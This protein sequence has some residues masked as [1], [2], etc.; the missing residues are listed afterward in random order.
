MPP[1][2]PA[3]LHPSRVAFLGGAQGPALVG[4][5]VRGRPPARGPRPAGAAG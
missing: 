5:A 2:D 3:P 4:R 1:A